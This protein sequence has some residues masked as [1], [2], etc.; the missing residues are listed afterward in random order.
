MTPIKKVDVEGVEGEEEDPF[1]DTV[2]EFELEVE[3]DDDSEFGL[4]DSED[5]EAVTSPLPRTDELPTA[6]L[7]VLDL[8]SVAPVEE[9]QAFSLEAATAEECFTEGQRLAREGSMRTAAQWMQVAVAKAP[10]NPHYRNAL[11]NLMLQI[12]RNG[13]VTEIGAALW[14]GR[15]VER[16]WREG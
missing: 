2:D 8:D 9:G 1:E 14:L 10:A 13:L 11:R 4:P 5:L 12:E 15:E 6:P 3:E 7:P 16:V